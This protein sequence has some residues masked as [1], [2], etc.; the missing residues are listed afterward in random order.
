MHPLRIWA[1]TCTNTFVGQEK[2]VS[3]GYF[4]VGFIPKGD[5]LGSGARGHLLVRLGLAV[6]NNNLGE[7]S[8]NGTLNNLRLIE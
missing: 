5:H 7:L 4:I 2:S 6:V 1:S 8:S 3:A